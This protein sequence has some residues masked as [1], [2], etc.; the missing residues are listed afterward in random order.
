MKDIYNIL[1]IEPTNDINIIKKQ[2]R[3]LSLKYHPDKNNNSIDYNNKF[4]ELNNA[5]KKILLE[6]NNQNN[7]NNHNNQNNLVKYND[8]NIDNTNQ[9]INN[10]NKLFDINDL[11]Y[12]I[13]TVDITMIQSYNGYCIP[14]EID[15]FNI[16]N[17]IIE[18]NKET[19][20]VKIPKGID[21]N[22]YININNI[23]IKVN[24]INNTNFIR[25]G[26]DLVYEKNITLKESLCGFSFKINHL[27]GKIIT[28][29]N[30]NG[31]IISPYEETIV[32]NLGMIRDNYIGD[33][34]IKY[35][36]IFPKNI[37]KDKIDKLN[38]IL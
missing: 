32:K 27:N 20:Y 15:N 6:F 14:I 16:V 1:E 31:K 7:K 13:K 19:I 8:V 5:Y 24:I 11:N 21:N 30:Y 35:N 38:N 37:S 17:N 10:K 36:I 34:I 33:L 23:K 9:N 18:K 22:E 26:I 12:Q 25:K 29:N 3:K 2:Y 28:I 4:N